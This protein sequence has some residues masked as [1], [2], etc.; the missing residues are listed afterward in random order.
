MATLT[1]Q[2]DDAVKSEAQ[3]VIKKTGLSM[4]SVIRSYL[5]QIAQS[6]DIPFYTAEDSPPLLYANA[7]GELA[8]TP[9]FAAI[10]AE[11]KEDIRLNRN[12]SPPVGR[13][14]LKAYLKGWR[15]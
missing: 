8:P 3:E 5:K 15:E 6:R 11:A 1:I 4:A 7:S 13:N 12:L 10:I 2:I 9:Y 14:E